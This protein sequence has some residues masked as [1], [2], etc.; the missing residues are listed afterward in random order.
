VAAWAVALG[1]LRGSVVVGVLAI[2]WVAAIGAFVGWVWL[3]NLWSRSGTLSLLE[4]QRD[5]V[6]L[7]VAAAA[8]L[9]VNART[10]RAVLSGIVVAV[11]AAN[12]YGFVVEVLPEAAPTSPR[13][14]NLAEPIGY[15]N[16]MGLLAA[17]AI[18]LA[19]MF[20]SSARSRAGR[21]LAGVALAA[22]L[23]CLYL[24]LAR[25][26]WLALAIGIATSIGLAQRPRDA[27]KATLVILPL[28]LVATVAV[29]FLP[30]GSP[31][32]ADSLRE[33]ILVS[34]LAGAAALA[35]GLVAARLDEILR[36][37]RLGRTSLALA[38]AGV[39]AVVF[40]AATSAHSVSVGGLQSRFGGEFGQL[41]TL[42]G[43]LRGLYWSAAFRGYEDHPLVGS[44][45]GTFEQ[46]WLLHRPTRIYNVLDAHNAYLEV[47]AELGPIGIGLFVTAI[48]LPLVVA[49]RTSRTALVAGAAGAYAAYAAHIAVD[50]DWELPALT[51]TALL[52]ASTVLACAEQ[53]RLSLSTPTRGIAF[54][55]ACVVGAIS[56]A[57]LLANGAIWEGSGALRRGDLTRARA[58][59]SKAGRWSLWSVEP[60]Q[61]RGEVALTA[62]NRPLAAGL[63]RRALRREPNR[64]W[65][66]IDLAE[67]TSGAE[68]RRAL[69]RA[70]EL[71]PL[72][73]PPA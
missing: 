14:A 68:Q 53:R 21:A 38:A 44:G 72:E 70:H 39:A 48:G 22:L 42:S 73:L 9:F 10:A 50:W 54:A 65:L 24:S 5:V 13:I 71:N 43:H 36:R 25:G 29:A 51:V 3:S 58:E 64:Y 41:S 12:V 46:L 7:A 19:L 35:N 59:A 37:A 15:P 32:T 4:G 56:L 2:A 52:C 33:R 66:W 6:Y 30:T 11:V 28:P 45:A 31:P 62:G 16:A 34:A 18:V 67:A 26:P 8:A 57:G 60:D 17:Q 47:L 61:L 63:F 27:W 55:G 1:L 69:T 40:V 49:L 23:P 20:A